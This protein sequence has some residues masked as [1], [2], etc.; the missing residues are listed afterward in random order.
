MALDVK[1]IP[2]KIRELFSSFGGNSFSA[3][4]PTRPAFAPRTDFQTVIGVDEG[5]KTFVFYSATT[6]DGK[7]ISIDEY[8]YG[9]RA[10]G[11]NFYPAFSDAV[12]KF[13]NA[14]PAAS[15]GKAVVV[16]PD[17]A[18]AKDLISLPVLNKKAMDSALR[19]ELIHF[20]QN[21]DELKIHSYPASKNKQY[22]VYVISAMR[23]D[24][25]TAIYTA[26]S[27]AKLP[28]YAITYAA[29]A[30]TNAVA[31][32][33][34]KYK[35]SSYLLLDVKEESAAVAIVTKG[36]TTG[37]Y[38]LPF[39]YRILSQNRLAAED[40]LFDHTTA[41][42]AVLNAKERARAKQLTMSD[43]EIDQSAPIPEEGEEGAP[44]Q[45]TAETAKTAGRKTARKLPKFM[46]RE[47]DPTPEGF[48]Y[49]NF[50][51]F[52]KWT[53]L[54]I[55]ANE[56]IMRLGQPSAILVRM[57][58]QY[59]YLL[60]RLKEEESENGIEFRAFSS[61]DDLPDVAE[62]LE[63]YGGFFVENGNLPNNF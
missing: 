32:L 47:F 10:F 22:A 21:H 51:L 40:L 15:G 50:R 17:Y 33:S 36:R 23:K 39:G 30:A 34:P 4:K 9:G 43:S 56:S 38:D 6:S 41:E 59:H 58:E 3:K 20:Y 31:A 5:K 29:S 24:I 26:C 12:T 19:V 27:E 52:V 60:D 13:V 18:V 11:E 54:Q 53:L 62:H 46:L 55:R 28:L 61:A 25:L 7:N 8:P 57:P 14:H 42:I 35:S 45:E 49:E 63:L 48:A 44:A 37:S 2:Q 1:D 16:L